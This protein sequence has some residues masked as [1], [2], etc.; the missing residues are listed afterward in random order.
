[1]NAK[2]G[3][4]PLLLSMLNWQFRDKDSPALWSAHLSHW[5]LSLQQSSWSKWFQSPRTVVLMEIAILF[6]IIAAWIIP[7]FK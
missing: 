7:L 3:G 4:A 1:M 6:S 2:V 5:W